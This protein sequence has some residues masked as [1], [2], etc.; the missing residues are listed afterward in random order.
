LGADLEWWEEEPGVWMADE[1]G[2]DPY[3]AMDERHALR[4]AS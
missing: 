4:D 3:A 1:D 2:P